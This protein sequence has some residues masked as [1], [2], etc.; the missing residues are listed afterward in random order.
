MTRRRLCSALLAAALAAGCALPP[1]GGL[2]V[3]GGLLTGG[4]AVRVDPPA[5][6]AP[7]WRRWN[8]CLRAQHAIRDGDPCR[9]AVAYRP[10][11]DLREFGHC[12][13][14]TPKGDDRGHAPS[15]RPPGDGAG[16][17]PA[18]PPDLAELKNLLRAD[19]GW[20]DGSDGHVG[21]GAKL[22][23]ASGAGEALLDFHA[24]QALAD[25]AAAVG[26]EAWRGLARPR[27]LALA[28]MAYQMGREGLRGFGD[29]LAAVRERRWPDAAAAMLDSKWAREDAP[30][31]AARLAAMM[32][33]GR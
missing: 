31:R 16:G 3:D 5:P 17:D 32:R 13:P 28:S 11:A 15:P 8:D 27:R 18:E 1:G 23:L 7:E 9:C 10:L 30:A 29:A 6:A 12:F 21:W 20:S 22:P 25:A 4:A 24:R 14:N 33:A 26:V 19:E 2:A